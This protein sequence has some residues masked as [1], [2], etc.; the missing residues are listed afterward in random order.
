MKTLTI[1]VTCETDDDIGYALDEVLMKV[2]DGYTSGF[3]GTET[4]SYNFDVV[5]KESSYVY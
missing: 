4:G 2:E 1:T 3:G 5:E